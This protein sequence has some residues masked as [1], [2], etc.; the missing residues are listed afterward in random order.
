MSDEPHSGLLIRAIAAYKGAVADPRHFE[1]I[2]AR[3]VA[4]ARRTADAEALVVGLRAQAWSKRA[5]LA[6]SSAKVLL[7]EAVRVARRQ[8]LDARLGEVLVTRAAVNHELGRLLAAQHDLDHAGLLLQDEGSAE[9]D[10][11]Q[12]ALLQN[13]GRLAEAAAL[14]RRVLAQAASPAAVRAIMANNLALIDAQYGY[15]DAALERLTGAAV[16]AAEVG[17]AVVALVAQSRGWVTVQ[18]GRLA[19]SLRLFDHAAHLYETA[20]LPL[21]EPYLEHVD[22]LVDLRLLP[23]ATEMARRAADQF[24][25]SGVLLMGAEAKLRIAQLALLGRDHEG[26]VAAAASA[27]QQ[28]RRQRRTAWAARAT[29]VEADAR[30]RAGAPS[31][32][33]LAAARR[34]AATLEQLGI[35]SNAVEAHLTAGRIALA[36]GRDRVAVGS[37][38]RAHELASHAPVLVR[39]KGRVAAALAAGVDRR[40][41]AVLHHCRAGLTEL[42]QHRAALPSMELRALASAHGAELGVLGFKM[43]L[44]TGSASRLL[45]WMERTRAAA[46]LAVEPPTTDGIEEGLAALR[47]VHAEL[48]R[49]GRDG[50]GDSPELLARQA[51]IERSVRRATWARRTAAEVDDVALS[52][53]RLR[54]FLDGRNLVEYGAVEGQLFAVVL[55]A[56]QVRL[57][58]L[59]Q[60]NA[61]QDEADA[62]VFALRRLTRP[63]ASAV[64]ATARRTAQVSLEQLTELLI[65]PLGL[66]GDIPLV[67]V[68]SRLSQRIPWSAL[69]R[70]PVSVVPSASFWV[71]TGQR[72]ARTGD[73]VLVA[74]PGLSGA[75]AEVQSLA[76]LHQRPAVMSPPASTVDAVVTALDGAALA[77]LACHGRLRSDNP[78]FSSLLLSDG[79]LTLHELDLRGIAPHRIILAACDTAAAVGYEGDEVLGFV[80]ALMARGTAGL[81]ASAVMVP[82]L[83]AVALMH[84]LHEQLL[85]GATLADA[86]HAARSAL[87]RD[88]AGA[89]VNWCAFTAFG[90]A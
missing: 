90:A 71:R 35:S 8:Q 55:Q 31:A 11:Q 44:R 80:T 43:L 62:L 1:P 33:H 83:E 67:V 68:P 70:A 49:A 77:H 19:E 63:G 6:N 17:P 61:V 26:A 79:P 27:A 88:D 56:R 47:A 22:A 10:L 20:G 78:T 57:V 39:L 4:D 65:R 54:G 3:V 69:H 52:S 21:G 30:F 5:Q 73:V 32:A 7:D 59:G 60:L 82:D 37:L 18:A 87:G 58:P 24:E 29:A 9:L 16:L 12:A 76:E 14:Y 13:I 38:Q 64:L 42:M 66:P 50:L 84:S 75:A 15:H 72:R 48:A 2:A 53:S 23:E 28:F 85:R 81:V 89:F 25:A 34:A 86:L 46:L 45:D 74:G 41:R 51:A 36:L 40:D